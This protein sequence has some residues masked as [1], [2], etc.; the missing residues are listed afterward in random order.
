VSQQIISL[1]VCH[2][3]EKHFDVR[4]ATN[5]EHRSYTAILKTLALLF[6]WRAIDFVGLIYV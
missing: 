5:G 4:G 1:A 6:Q 3:V 2:A